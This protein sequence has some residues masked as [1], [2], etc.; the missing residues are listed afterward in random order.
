MDAFRTIK[1]NHQQEIAEFLRIAGKKED[2]A[3]HYGPRHLAIELLG[4]YRA[5]DQEVVRWLSDNVTLRYNVAVSER[6][7][8]SG[9]VCAIA[10]SKIGR[11]AAHEIF[12]RVSHDRTDKELELFTHVL[13][14]NDD[15]E[16]AVTRF[17]LEQRLKG[18]NGTHK[19]NLEKMLG[20]LPKD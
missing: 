8:L 7:P 12:A 20:Y 19:R 5:D 14:H 4:E 10:L 16:I 3:Q 17:R 1:L 9:Y 6:T 15:E 2:I 18:A 13:I 11:A